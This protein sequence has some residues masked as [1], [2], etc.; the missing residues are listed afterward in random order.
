MTDLA[1]LTAEALAQIGASGSLAA[2]DELRVHWLGRK[3]VLTEQLKSLGAL[4]P[5]ARP[6]AG[7]RINAAGRSGCHRGAPR[8]A[9]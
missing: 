8:A 2:L 7:A 5:A 1:A 4:A 6:A 9:R 3:G